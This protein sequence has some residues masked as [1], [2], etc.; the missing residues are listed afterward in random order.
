MNY[1]DSSAA[2][3]SSGRL[4]DDMLG[5]RARA[6][7][8]ELDTA[9]VSLRDMVLVLRRGKWIVKLC[10][11]ISLALAVTYLLRTS[12]EYTATSQVILEPRRLTAPEAV[13]GPSA[14]LDSAQAESQMQVVKSERILST[15]FDALHLADAPEFAHPRPGLR[16]RL[17][18]AL[19]R[20][21]AWLAPEPARNAVPDP[22]GLR[23]RAFQAFTDRV[24]VRR[25]GQSYVLEISYRARSPV[26][27]SRL[28]NSIT[29]AYIHSQIRRKLEAAR[30]GAE[31]LEN[32]VSVLESEEAAGTQAIRDGT[33]PLMSFP[34]AE[35][36][37]ISAAREPLAKSSPQ[38]L[39]VLFFG[40]VA[41]LLGGGGIVAVRHSLD[42]R[43][44]TA[45]QVWR[46][47]GLPC[48]SVM[49]VG[50]KRGARRL[51][52]DLVLSDPQ[53]PFA[54]ALRAAYT[55]VVTASARDATFRSL[56][57]V[58]WRPGEGKSTFAGNLAHFIAAT[59]ENVVLIDADLADP[60]LSEVLAPEATG[61]LGEAVSGASELGEL[62]PQTLRRHLGLVPA[63]G[64]YEPQRPNLFLGTAAMGR[65]LGHLRDTGDVVVDLPAMAQ[66]PHAQAIAA[67]LDG[68]I[69]VIESGRT[70]ID[71]AA[72]AIRTLEGARANLLGIVLNKGDGRSGT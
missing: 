61:S 40:L 9:L 41:G 64:R 15:V 59:G 37:V 12:P 55:A 10:L 38:T 27:A 25:I 70:T 26:E 53:A 31:F 72:T 39:L 44:H 46:H 43:I 33:I 51:P 65:F 56:G 5:V 60:T 71:E 23:E 1:I 24:S 14:A 48:L 32:R 69:L 17:T 2:R 19:G 16:Q 13:S 21:S 22:D 42:R 6:V 66:A 57:V 3:H 52:F 36:R 20:L 68:V 63:R 30:R 58:S 49:P 45:G 47:F 35:S 8:P 67:F 18:A 34:D 7:G 62:T 11:V 29:A 28:T 4:P 54:R 50:R